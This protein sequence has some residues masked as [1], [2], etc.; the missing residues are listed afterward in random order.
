MGYDFD[1]IMSDVRERGVLVLELGVEPNGRPVYR[2]SLFDGHAWTGARY[3]T[4]GAA[5]TT[6]KFLRRVI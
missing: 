3:H 2:V 1:V 4:L 5:V 6:Y